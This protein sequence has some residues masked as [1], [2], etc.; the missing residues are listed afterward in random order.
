MMPQEATPQ[1]LTLQVIIERLDLEV[2][3]NHKDFTQV[4]PAAGYASDLLSCVMAGAKQKG[5]WVT[6]Q[7]HVNIV[8][9][10]ALLELSAI[11]ITEGARPDETTIERANEQDV[12]LLVTPQTTF[13][14][15]GKLWEM[16]LKEA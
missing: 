1:E 15:S 7:A 8:A 13:T 11:I 3:T 14:I 12:T 5:V 4:T 2:L 16:G 9:I 10:A 6:L